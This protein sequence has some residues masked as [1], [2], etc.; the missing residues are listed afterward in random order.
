M[1]GALVMAARAHLQVVDR[2][3]A[4]EVARRELGGAGE[5]ERKANDEE[6]RN[7]FNSV[8]LGAVSSK[9][10]WTSNSAK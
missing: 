9:D 10:T 1:S 5:R 6:L 2:R 7:H 3:A 8:R 4:L